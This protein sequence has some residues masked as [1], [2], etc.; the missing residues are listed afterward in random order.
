MNWTKKDLLE[1]KDLTKDEILL[2]LETAESFKEI[3]LREIKKVPTLRGKTVITL[4]YE[5]STR[6]RTSFEIAAKR[7]SAD[8]I[9]I[10]ASTSSF[11]KGETLKD[12]GKNLESMKPDVIIIRHSMPGAPH[13][14]A[15][16]LKSS[17][18]NAG[19]GA[20]EHPTQALLDLFTIK[21]KKGKI[22]G[23]KIVII[24]DIM[25][26]R[27][28]R[29][30]IFALKQFDTEIVC[31]GPATMIPPYIEKLGVAVEYNINRAV[32]DADVVMM[33]RIQKER[34][35]ISYIPSIR[36]YAILYGL[37]KAHL[38]KAKKDVIVMHPGPMNR[39]VEISDEVAD[40]E[41]S[42]ILDQVENGVAVRMA[43]L[44]LLTGR[45][46]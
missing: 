17:I 10:S 26:S 8:T 46:Q 13:I 35:G 12:T 28:A 19:D 37:K 11:V 9:N 25:H 23:L 39:G 7:L 32:K 34:G 21:E 29:S 14:L 16:T 27:V 22:D 18:I 41:Y 3:S 6:T 2:I 45:E 33:L 24:G 20:H 1:I 36:E 15:R 38:E 31:C 4:F 40:G 30:N 44:Y 5:P 42:V 43:I